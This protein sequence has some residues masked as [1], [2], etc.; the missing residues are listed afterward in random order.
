MHAVPLRNEENTL[1]IYDLSKELFSA[2]VFPGDPAP[3]KTPFLEISETCPC[4]VTVLSMGSHNGTHMDAPKHFVAGAGDIAGIPLEK[5]VGPCK[6]V[7]HSGLVTAEDAAAMLQDGTKRLLIRGAIELT[8]EAAQVFAAQGLW[9]LGVEHWTVGN[10]QT[11]GDI[12]RTLLGAEIAL[13]EAAVMAEVPA[14]SYLLSSAPLRM[15]G[16]DGSPCRPLLIEL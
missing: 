12:H 3:S 10:S 2:A 7:C 13:L 8:V 11:G 4:N 1:K 9:F 16:L 6:V 5:C 14:G 15:Q